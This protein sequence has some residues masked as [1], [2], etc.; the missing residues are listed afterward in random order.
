MPLFAIA[1]SEHWYSAGQTIF[2][3]IS[4]FAFSNMM[5]Q[6]ISRIKLSHSPLLKV[7]GTKTSF[8]CFA[9][10]SCLKVSTLNFL[11]MPTQ[12]LTDVFPS[13]D[14][15]SIK[16]ILSKLTFLQASSV[17]SV[18]WVTTQL[19]VSQFY[20]NLTYSCSEQWPKIPCDRN[21]ILSFS[22]KI[23]FSSPDSSLINLLPSKNSY[24]QQP[25]RY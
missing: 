1:P 18:T 16:P 3:N 11:T 7:E 24:G 15:I 21:P 22:R 8:Y 4:V 19:S 12:G 5:L 9:N 6:C 25:F 2:S 14:R 10:T 17:I 23:F 13:P 20:M